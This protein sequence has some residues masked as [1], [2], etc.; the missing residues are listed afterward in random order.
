MSKKDNYDNVLDKERSKQRTKP[1]SKYIIV[2]INDDFTPMDFVAALIIQ[3]CNKSTAEAL[4]ITQSVHEKG[5][6]I[7]G[8]PYTKEIAETKTL[9]MLNIARA[10]GHPLQVIMEKS[11]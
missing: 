3:I 7:A 4:A 11:E 5:K 2:L 9:K 1:P 10:S 6:G 8:G